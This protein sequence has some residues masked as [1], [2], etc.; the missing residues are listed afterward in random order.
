MYGLPYQHYFILTHP[1]GYTI[2]FHGNN[3]FE[4][5]FEIHNKSVFGEYYVETFADG[6][7]S[8]SLT[9][10]MLNRLQQVEGMRAY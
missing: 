7:T 8:T 1:K 3:H 4:A 9:Q 5:S 6:N 2:E 10:E